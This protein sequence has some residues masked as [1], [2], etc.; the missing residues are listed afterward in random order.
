[1][2]FKNLNCLNLEIQFEPAQWSKVFKTQKGSK[3]FL[4]GISR[5]GDPERRSQG[6]FHTR[7]TTR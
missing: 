1:M 5:F 6:L 4:S 2:S 3:W 7:E